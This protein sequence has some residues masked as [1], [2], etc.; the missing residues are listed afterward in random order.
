MSF[1]SKLF[2]PKV[3]KYQ[4]TMSL[5]YTL[6]N[7]IKFYNLFCHDQKKNCLALIVKL[8]KLFKLS[9]LKQNNFNNETVI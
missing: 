1:V 8:L 3:K 4:I 7:H 2:T 9:K 5:R 6:Y